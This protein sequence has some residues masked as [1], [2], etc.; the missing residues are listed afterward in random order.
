MMIKCYSFVSELHLTRLRLEK[1]SIKNSDLRFFSL[2]YLREMGSL[3]QIP[4]EQKFK[5]NFVSWLKNEKT[6]TGLLIK[7]TITCTF[8]QKYYY[9]SLDRNDLNT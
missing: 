7:N 9:W 3:G 2:S 1:K 4:F 5:D 6:I 8:R